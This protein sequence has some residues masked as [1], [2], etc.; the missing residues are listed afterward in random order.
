M[1]PAKMKSAVLQRTNTQKF[2]FFCLATI[3]TCLGCSP[4]LIVTQLSNSKQSR[5]GLDYEPFAF[6]EPE[7]I[8]YSSNEMLGRIEIKDAGFRRCC[9][10]VTYD[11]YSP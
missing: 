7:D 10:F 9:K 11:D 5:L 1:F 3:L 2:Y 6:L 8:D 4:K